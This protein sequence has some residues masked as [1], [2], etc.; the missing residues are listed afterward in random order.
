MD[1]FLAELRNLIS[2]GISFKNAFIEVAVYCVSADTPA[3]AVLKD[4]IAHN[5]YYGCK[6]CITKGQY[7][8]YSMS[9][10][11][12]KEKLRTDESFEKWKISE[13]HIK[14][15]LLCGIIKMVTQFPYDYMHLV[16]FGVTKRILNISLSGP[17]AT[18]LK[19]TQQ[20]AIPSFILKVKQLVCSEFA[21]KPRSFKQLAHWKATEY[22]LFLLHVGPVVMHD[23]LPKNQYDHFLLRNVKISIFLDLWYCNVLADSANELLHKFIIDFQ[24]F[25]PTSPI[26]YNALSLAHFVDDVK[27]FGVLDNFFWFP[28]ET[29]FG[30]LKKLV[31][32]PKNSIVLADSANE[33]LHKFIIDFQNFYPTS[34]IVYNARSLAHF[35]DDVKKF[36]VLDNFFWFPFETFFGRL[37]KLVRGPKNS[38]ALVAQRLSER[39][40]VLT[41]KKH[42]NGYNYFLEQMDGLEIN[43][44]RT[45]I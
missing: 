15:S 9:F 28:F 2:N 26:V 16:C 5:G 25:Y 4:I 31:R 3:R 39:V 44:A 42:F 41:S 24:N 17:K 1:K 21:R 33:L 32:G 10:P 14:E 27:K 45:E 7:I 19:K 11:Q 34:P 43:Y 40:N 13:H 18:R 8:M 30:R 22:R 23:V 29:F 38:I 20:N 36:G 37:K 12:L 6:K 35:V